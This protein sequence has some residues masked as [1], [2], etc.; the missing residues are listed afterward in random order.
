MRNLFLFLL[1]FYFNNVCSHGNKVPVERHLFGY[2]FIYIK[3]TNFNNKLDKNKLQLIFR[4]PQYNS[5]LYLYK[6]QL[7]LTVTPSIKFWIYY[8]DINFVQGVEDGKL[9]KYN[10]KIFGT[11]RFKLPW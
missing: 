8:N 4:N 11:F 1:I 5:P 7:R 3:E 6:D 9:K 2:N 10:L